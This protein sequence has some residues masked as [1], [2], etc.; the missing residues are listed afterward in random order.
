MRRLAPND[1]FFV[2]GYSPSPLLPDVIPIKAN[3]QITAIATKA[4]NG[5]YCDKSKDIVIPSLLLMNNE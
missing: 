1:I 2:H 4:L 5:I 3:I